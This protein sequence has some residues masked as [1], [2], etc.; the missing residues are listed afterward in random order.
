ML[1]TIED[2][3]SRNMPPNY[4]F[5]PVNASSQVFLNMHNKGHLVSPFWMLFSPAI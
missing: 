1:D 3:R 4:P 2:A 5:Y